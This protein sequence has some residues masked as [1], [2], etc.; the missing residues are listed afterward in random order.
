MKE[1]E[2]WMQKLKEKLDDYVEPVPA[3]G[4]GRLERGLLPPA[5]KRIMPYRR[6]W[7]AAAAAILVAAVSSVSLYFLDSPVADGIRHT[8]VSTLATVPDEGMPIQQEPVLQERGAKSVSPRTVAVTNRLIAKNDRSA[9]AL[10]EEVAAQHGVQE[11]EIGETENVAET[12]PEA[13]N[14]VLVSV[15]RAEQTEQPKRREVRRPSGKD[16][17]HLPGPAL[18]AKGGRWSIG[19]SIGNAGALSGGGNSEN[20]AMSR[21]QMDMAS[22]PNGIIKI[23]EGQ[24]V[25]FKEGVPYL[26]D[27]TK[28]TDIS[29]H[30]PVSF[31]LSVRKDL[32]KGF[33][34]ETGLT[35]TLLSSDVK[36]GGSDRSEDQKLHYVGIPVRANWNFVNK[37]MVTLYV[38]AGGAVEKCVYGELA[39]EKQTVKPLQLSLTGAV[40]AQVNATD[41]LGFYIEPGVSYFFNDGSSA[42]TI[43]K[44]TPCNF[45]LQAGVRFTY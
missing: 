24:T 17:L 19:A 14:E 22:S 20:I 39:G 6:R 43:R 44:E 25:V 11:N 8:S 36:I 5:E 29:H 2:M 15:D 16:K 28:I 35:Y 18:A 32:K 45:N 42:Q 31:G 4:W 13:V 38:A 33:S 9:A 37:K 27:L 7:V 30:Q 21:M 26:Q 41:R 40:G 23:P 3:S 10:N 12:S 34:I 1:K